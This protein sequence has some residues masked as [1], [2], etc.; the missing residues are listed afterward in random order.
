MIDSQIHDPEQR[1][2]LYKN[3][4]I[5]K[6]VNVMWFRNALDEGVSYP[7]HFQ[8]LKTHTVALV[9]T[10]VRLIFTTSFKLLIIY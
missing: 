5:Q 3:P 6:I 4:L 10:V 2:G 9:L 8:P 7:D 1:S